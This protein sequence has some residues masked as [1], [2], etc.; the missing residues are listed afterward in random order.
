MTIAFISDLHLDPARP[1]ATK[2]FG[3]FMRQS[4]RRLRQVYILGDLF[5]V[6]IGDD[7]RDAMGQG[8]VENIIKSTIDAG[9]EIFFMRGN[10]DFLVGGEF[11]KRTGCKILGD[12]ALIALD[13]HKI[14]LT[15]GDTLCIDDIEHQAARKEMI[16]AKWKLAFLNKSIDERKLVAQ[17]MRKRSESNKQQKSMEIMEI[18]DVNQRHVEKVMRHHGVATLIHGHTHKPAVHAFCLDGK[19]AKRYVLGD[20]YT[21]KSVLYYHA[22]RFTLRE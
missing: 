1:D 16:S 15:H 22:G 10:R 8:E 17:Q 5:E 6:W 19:P 9:L 3:E 7:G 13:A 21:Q 14:L 11:A 12:P 18:M 20:W 4:T 2:W